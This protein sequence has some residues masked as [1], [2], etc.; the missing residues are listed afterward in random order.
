M[1]SSKQKQNLYNK[2]LKLTRKEIK[3][4]KEIEIIYKAYENLFEAIRKNLKEP[5]TL[6]Y[7]KK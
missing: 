3:R 7:F 5:I 4:T 2:F 1:K 6:N